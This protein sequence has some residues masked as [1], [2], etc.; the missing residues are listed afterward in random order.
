M[1]ILVAITH[2]YSAQRTS[3]PDGRWHGSV[4]DAAAVRARALWQCIASLHQLY[5]P[6]QCIIEHVTRVAQECERTDRR[7]D[8]HRRL[9]DR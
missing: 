8:R 3:S 1:R 2:Y 6:A 7:Q 5:G 9:H 4:G